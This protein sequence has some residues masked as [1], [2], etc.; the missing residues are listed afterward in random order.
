MA[1]ASSP[2]ATLATSFTM[3]T[4]DSATLTTAENIPVKN[5]IFVLIWF[6]SYTTQTIFT[7]PILIPNIR[8]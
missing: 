4:G 5:P 1:S 8:R 3:A 2:M 6:Q 7:D